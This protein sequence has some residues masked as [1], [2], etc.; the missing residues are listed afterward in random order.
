[1]KISKSYSL[2]AAV[3][4]FTLALISW[5]SNNSKKELNTS[6]WSY[7]H[8]ETSQGFTE[9]EMTSFNADDDWQ[10]TPGSGERLPTAEDVLIQKIPGD[11]SHLIMMA[12]YSKENYSGQSVTI[13]SGGSNIVFRDDGKG[14]D[15][16]AGDGFY[17]AKISADVNEFRQKAMN[18]SEEMKKKGYRPF[19]F[20]HRALV[21]DPDVSEGFDVQKMD[22]NEVVSVSGLT[23]ALSSDLVTA[24]AVNAK[25]ESIRTHS[26]MITNLAVVEDPTR[27]WNSCTQTGNIDGP[28]TFKTIMK[29]LASS[30]PLNLVTDAQLSNFVKSWLNH[31][32]NDQIINGDTV[33]AR[34]L[35]NTV[36]LSPWLNKS[37]N[38][39]A[40][41]GQL[42]MRFAPFKL[43]AIVNRFDLRSGTKDGII[44]STVGEGRFVFGLI[45]ANC[46]VPQR[47]TVILE[48][49]VNKPSGCADKQAWAQQWYNLKDFTVGSTEYN[50]ALQ[51]I[52]DQFSLC[53]SNPNKPNQSSLDQVRTNEAVLADDG[54]TW[55]MKEF[56]LDPTT[57][58][59]KENTV[60]QTPADRYN[61]QTSNADVQRFANYVKQNTKA[62]SLETNAVPLTWQDSPFLGAKSHIFGVPAGAPP[63]V[64]HWDGTETGASPTFIKSVQ[65]RFFLSINTCAGCHAGET[66]T[67][68]THV[69]PVFYGTEATLS[70]FL[71]GK[72]GQGGAVDS[73]NNPDNDSMAVKDAALRPTADNPK[74]RIFNELLRRAKDLKTNAETTCG[75]VLNISSE[76]MF[77]PLNSVD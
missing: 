76:L 58:L 29:Q 2:S 51:N 53:G 7:M 73:D 26:M 22:N 70:G 5:S 6:L 77:K 74:I 35:V 4:I 36:I 55:E 41:T 17:T 32:A 65:A 59:L 15:K 57:H 8:D 18:M 24:A 34:T 14:D 46:L 3:I 63:G 42:D 28:W 72:A 54:N 27:T 43:L 11:R 38:G 75:S 20:V 33:K 69:D 66:Q 21:Y 67:S 37:R 10:F 40:P 56:I 49:S 64:F 19:R 12:F 61:A 68:F 23:N 62:I 39:G 50:Q 30:D 31:W 60:T 13:N 16:K 44:G 1:M 71:T 47:M 48:Y 9:A 52:T 25:V 45:K